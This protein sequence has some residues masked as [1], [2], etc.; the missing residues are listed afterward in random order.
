MD[1][2]LLMLRKLEEKW[3]LDI[4]S[5]RL[6][7][8]EKSPIKSNRLATVLIN[9]ATE[10]LEKE[11]ERIKGENTIQYLLKTGMELTQTLIKDILEYCEHEVSHCCSIYVELH[12]NV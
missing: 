12:Q 11:Q 7:P 9:N 1:F 3:N 8:S 2:D 4:F 6:L 5:K 10:D